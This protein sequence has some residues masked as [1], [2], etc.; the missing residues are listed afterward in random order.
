MEG[1]SNYKCVMQTDTK[2]K[3]Y[4]ISL[5]L[6]ALMINIWNEWQNQKERRSTTFYIKWD[7]KWAKKRQADVF[8]HREK[9]AWEN[10]VE[11]EPN[12]LW[13][14]TDK[15]ITKYYALS[16]SWAL[17]DGNHKEVE[18]GWSGQNW[19]LPMKSKALNY[20]QAGCGFEEALRFCW[21]YRIRR[22]WNE[23]KQIFYEC[24]M[25]P[26]T[27]QQEACAQLGRLLQNLLS[28]FCLSHNGG[29]GHVNW[30]K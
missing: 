12:Y 5:S 8:W 23:P 21:F 16:Y 17:A 1:G 10:Y 11:R 13:L 22:Q 27:Q 9:T 15:N 24:V 14:I 3:W 25:L 6:L 2:N 28:L 19:Q 20:R 29:S 18:K 4:K 26:Y 7:I 30:T